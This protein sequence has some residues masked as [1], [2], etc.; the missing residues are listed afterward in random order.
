MPGAEARPWQLLTVHVVLGIIH[1][2]DV[3]KRGIEDRV[4]EL[5][6]MGIRTVMV[7][8]DNPLTGRP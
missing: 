5:R 7:T 2:K 3:V 6:M 4:A 8:G 1:L